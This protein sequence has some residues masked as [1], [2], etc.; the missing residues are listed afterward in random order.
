MLV[1]HVGYETY[2]APSLL[3]GAGKETVLAVELTEAVTQMAEFVATDATRRLEP[4]D[5]MTAVSARP[6]PM[7]EAKRYAAS[8]NDPAR[9]ASGYAGVSRATT[10]WKTPWW[11]AATPPGACSGGSKAWKF[12]TPTI[13]PKKALRAGA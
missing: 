3:V 12:L 10:T 4:L 8:L 9:V 11:C 7:A 2:A 5:G 6:L 1:S 13:L